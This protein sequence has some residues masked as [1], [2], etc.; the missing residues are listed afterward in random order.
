MSGL[1]IGIDDNVLL[2]YEGLLGLYGHAIWP[3]L[4]P[5]DEPVRRGRTRGKIDATAILASKPLPSKQRRGPRSEAARRDITPPRSDR[6]VSIP[7]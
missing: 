7:W 2:F 5:K 6:E 3:S 1:N 4:R